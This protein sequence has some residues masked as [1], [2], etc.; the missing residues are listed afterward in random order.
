MPPTHNSPFSR[1]FS[2]N[3]G[4]YGGNDRRGGRD[5]KPSGPLVEIG[6]ILHP[7]EE[8]VVAQITLKQK[9]PFP[10]ANIFIGQDKKVGRVDEVLGPL[11]DVYLSVKLDNGVVPSAFEPGQ[12]IFTTADKIMPSSRVTEPKGPRGA[13]KPRVGARTPQGRDGGSGG[14]GGFGGRGGGRGGGGGGRGGFG[15]RGGGGGGRGGRGRF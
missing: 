9:L 10:S 6:S 2:L 14:R 7:C 4:G 5:E 13:A 8:T 15:G 3:L 12:K 11:D 1:C